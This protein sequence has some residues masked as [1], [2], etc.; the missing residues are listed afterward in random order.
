MAKNENNFHIKRKLFICT[1]RNVVVDLGVC[2]HTIISFWGGRACVCM[3]VSVYSLFSRVDICTLCFDGVNNKWCD[4][5]YACEK[6]SA[7]HFIRRFISCNL[8]RDLSNV[9]NGLKIILFIL[10]YRIVNFSCGKVQIPVF[11]FN[12]RPVN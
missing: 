2:S 10:F 7:N 11:C 6:R 9:S 12:Q 5:T 4:C 8:H 3:D 1:K